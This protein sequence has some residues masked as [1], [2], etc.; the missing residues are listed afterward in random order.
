MGALAER[1]ETASVGLTNI[2]TMEDALLAAQVDPQY[3]QAFRGIVLPFAPKPHQI[4]GLQAMIYWHRMGLFDEARTGKSIQMYMAA[5]YFAHFNFKSVFLMPP[6]LF[7]QFREDFDDLKGHKLSVKIFD[8]GAVAREKM[9]TE[10]AM[11]PSKAPDCLIMSK[12]IFKKHV[13]DLIA[14]KYRCLFFDEC[15]IGLQ[16]SNIYTPKK[17]LTTYGAVQ[18]FIDSVKNGRLVLATGTPIS[19]ELAST[20]SLISLKTPEAYRSKREFDFIH[21]GY[22]PIVVRGPRGVR[23][24]HVLDSNGYK[25]LPLLHTNLYK[26]AVR[27]TKMDVLS[28]EAPN[29]QEIPIRLHPGHYELYRRV[30]RDRLLEIDGELLDARQASQMRMTALQLI[31]DPESY[32]DAGKK[33]QNAVIE[34][35][36]TL[37]DTANVVQ[38]KVVLF[39]NFNKSVELL[40]EH[41]KKL[42]PAVVY[43]PNGPDKNRESAARFKTDEKCRILVAN[44]IAG[45]VGLK[46]GHVSQTVILVEPVSTPG[47]FDQSISRVILHGQTE[48]VS[49]YI[50]RVLNTISPNAISLMLGKAEQANEVLRDKKTLLDTLLGKG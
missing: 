24:V 39:A 1:H 48:P 5:I 37:L 10:I 11:A 44:P 41:F 33:I 49:V 20:Y 40:A 47:Q 28:I 34:G 25:D 4:V 50:L 22:K 30:I 17:Q 19:N 9:F 26:Q 12:E 21:V 32:C 31:T 45:G 3:A 42:N 23:T 2:R 38:N 8:M 18:R 15:H 16:S 35:V 27:A 6:A 43:G 46:L 7:D 36:Q 29:I 14:A 13:G